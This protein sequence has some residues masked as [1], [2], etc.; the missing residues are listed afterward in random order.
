MTN[1]GW[2]DGGLA[3]LLRGSWLW[4]MMGT[5]MHR[6]MRSEEMLRELVN[7]MWW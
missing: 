4:I 5:G 6:S 1:G 7:I 3:Y 2:C